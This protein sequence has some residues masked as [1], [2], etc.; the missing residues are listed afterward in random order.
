MRTRLYDSSAEVNPVQKIL[1][2]VT[3]SEAEVCID[4]I[5]EKD[6]EGGN[7]YGHHG[8]GAHLIVFV[9]ITPKY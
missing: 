6:D 5:S 1:L 8:G 3:G 4:E 9:Q 7:D 2:V